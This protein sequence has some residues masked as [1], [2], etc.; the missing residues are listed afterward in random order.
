MNWLLFLGLLSA[1]LTS[2]FVII[3]LFVEKKDQAIIQDWTGLGFSGLIL[4]IALLQTRFSDGSLLTPILF[5]LF[6]LGFT[7]SGVYYWIPNFIPDS[8]QSDATKYMFLAT[9]AS[10]ILVNSTNP[11]TSVQWS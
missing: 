9:T 8:K 6:V 1:L 11:T 7:L 10:I 3:P 2:I 5:Y 4:V